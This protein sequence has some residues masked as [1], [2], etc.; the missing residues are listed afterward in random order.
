MGILKQDVGGTK[1]E[2][3]EVKQ[4]LATLVRQWTA[5]PEH[6]R[7]ETSREWEGEK[8]ELKEWDKTMAVSDSNSTFHESMEKI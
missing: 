2:L 7:E 1:Q 5:G 3:G 8:N 6:A 4:L